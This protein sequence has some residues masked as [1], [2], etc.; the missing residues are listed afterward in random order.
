M[1]KLLSIFLN[2]SLLLLL[3]VS[4]HASDWTE[5]RGPARDGISLEKG[6]PSTWSPSGRMSPGRLLWWLPAPIV[7]R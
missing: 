3:L 7:G 1:T 5:W 2:V 4:V 6:L